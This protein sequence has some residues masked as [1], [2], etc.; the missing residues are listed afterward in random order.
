MQT[1]WLKAKI[2]IIS[3]LLNFAAMNIL[4][5]LAPKIAL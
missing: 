1:G 5:F 3:Q 4:L 2:L